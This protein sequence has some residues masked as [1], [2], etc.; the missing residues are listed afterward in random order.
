[1]GT[2]IR[3]IWQYFDRRRRRP[4]TPF[5][6]AVQWIEYPEA[7]GFTE[8]TIVTHDRPLLLEKI[9]CCPRRP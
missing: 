2:H 1:M 8:L 4:D 7:Q 5:E 6:A 9:C 3:A